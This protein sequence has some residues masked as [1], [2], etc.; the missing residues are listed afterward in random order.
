[1]WSFIPALEYLL[2]LIQL[3]YYYCFFFSKTFWSVQSTRWQKMLCCPKSQRWFAKINQPCV[4]KSLCFH[5]SQIGSRASWF[6]KAWSKHSPPTWRIPPSR[7]ERSDFNLTRWLL[8]TG[9][10]YSSGQC[11]TT[12]KSVLAFTKLPTPVQKQNTACPPPHLLATMH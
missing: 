6:W 11:R 8:K 1:M 10:A 2:D 5:L 9:E 7:R 3:C 4:P 12:L